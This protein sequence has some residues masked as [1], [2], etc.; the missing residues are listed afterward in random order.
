MLQNKNTNQERKFLKCGS[1]FVW[2]WINRCQKCDHVWTNEE[3]KQFNKT[4]K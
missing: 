1:T 3:E 2:L 4:I